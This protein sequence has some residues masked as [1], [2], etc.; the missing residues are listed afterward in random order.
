M[1]SYCADLHIHSVLSPCGDLEMSPSRIVE[2]AVQKGL[3]IIAI[4]DHNHTGHAKLVRR[5]GSEKG[6]WVVLGV[7]LNTREEVHCLTFFDTDIQLD[8]FQAELDRNLPRIPNNKDLFGSQVVVDEKEQV[9]SEVEYSLYPG[10]NWGISEAARVVHELGGLFIPAHINR[11][12]NGL[13]SQLGFLPEDLRIDAVEI[14]RNSKLEDLLGEH[15]ELLEYQ[16]YKSSDAHYLEDIGRCTSQ[17]HM[18]ERNFI[19]LGL[20]L[21]G[22]QGRKVTIN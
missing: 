8:A 3:E 6:I 13:Y 18:K 7:E 10:L 1:N 16:L 22:E 4:T 21:R 12:M 14:A 11:T 17:L 19:E 5:L 15:P 9:I 2:N 20:A